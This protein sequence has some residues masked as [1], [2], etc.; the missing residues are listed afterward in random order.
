MMLL[1]LTGSSPVSIS[2]KLTAS[3]LTIAL[4]SAYRLQ[5]LSLSAFRP[6]SLRFPC[7]F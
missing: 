6:L 7:L 1:G 2:I 5:L 4:S 3:G